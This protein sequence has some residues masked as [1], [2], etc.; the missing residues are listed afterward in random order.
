MFRYAASANRVAGR[1]VIVTCGSCAADNAAGRRFCDQCGASL[2]DAC[3]SC[4][5]QNRPEARF[6]GDC[7]Q[8]LGNGPDAAAQRAGSS[9]AVPIRSEPAAERRLVSVLFAD[10]VA[11][12]KYSEGRDPELVRETLTRYFESTRAVIERHGGQVEKFIGD[13]VMA[14]WGAQRAN[15]DDAER[16]V[17]AALEVVNAV[18]ELDEGLRARVGVLTGQAAVTLGATDQGMVAGDLVNTAARLQAVA[19]PDTVLVGEATMQAAT[20]AIAFEP[21]G[22]QVLKGKTAPV[23]AWRALRVVADKGGR[24]RGE[25]LEPPFVGREIELRLLKD[26]VNAASTEQRPRLVSITGPAG[27][28][29]S[30]LA[31]EFEKYVD[32]LVEQI[33][34]HRGRSPSYGEGIAFWALGEMVRRRAGLAEGDD[35]ATTRE[36]IHA[37]VSEFIAAGEAEWI[38]RS[39]LALLGLEAPPDGGRETLFAGWRTFFER[40]AARQTTVLVFED[41]QWADDGL[42]DFI[43]HLLEWSRDVP[44]LVVGLARPELLDERPGWG[45]GKRSFNAIGLEPLTDDQM[46]DLLR[47]LVP[48]MPD[49]AVAQVVARADGIPLYAVEMVR[50]LIADGSLVAGLDG[51]YAATRELGTLALPD[52]LRAL[53]ASRLDALDASDRALLQDA[54]I[55]GQ[56]FDH[57]ALARI[58][59]RDEDEVEARLRALMQ[60]ELVE[61]SVDPRSPD[62]GQYGFV[63]AVIREVA[64]ETLSRRDRRAR[65]LATARYYEAA[66][67]EEL[68]GV[69]AAHYLGAYKASDPGPEADA[70]GAQARRALV[71][72][73][74]R[75]LTLG[76]PAQALVHLES[77]LETT[78]DP[79]EQAGLLARAATAAS[80]AGRKD[81]AIDHAS[82]AAAI[83]DEAGQD[84]SALEALA[85][86]GGFQTDAGYDEDARKLL[87]EAAA[88]A[89]APEDADVRADLLAR[90]SRVHMR[91]QEEPEAIAA[92]DEALA[93]A[94]P[95]G[96]DRVTAEALINKSGTL[97][98]M[99]RIREPAILM[100]GA[101]DLAT[102]VGDIELQMRARA[103]LS[104]TYSHQ[105]LDLAIEASVEALEIARRL[106]TSG[107]VEWLVGGLVLFEFARGHDWDAAIELL[108]RAIDDTDADAD[109]MRYLFLGVRQQYLTMRGQETGGTVEAMR[110]ILASADFVPFQ[111]FDHMSAYETL[112]AGRPETAVREFQ[113]TYGVMARAIGDALAGC[114]IAAA[115]ARDVVAARDASKRLQEWDEGGRGGDAIRE[116]GRAVVHALEGR[117]ESATASFVR[118]VERM[119]AGKNHFWV[120]VLQAVALELQPGR[121]EHRSAGRRRPGRASSCWLPNPGCASSTLR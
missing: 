8:A 21:A 61:I 85:L 19:P 57:R 24:G 28:G 34:W 99:R 107:Y 50:M 13:A 16:A 36:R 71:S 115:Y 69:L 5:A 116:L 31:W 90:L 91:L 68:A 77:A 60:R 15:E 104:A 4:G 100:Q 114:S 105:D 37:A 6:C 25:G 74:A 81:L 11:F 82:R 76:S 12:T 65:H 92:A 118:A 102:E 66:G 9:A 119:R 109:Y 111:R 2:I 18:R 73:A 52:T 3:P 29:K 103:N 86:K 97:S 121:P 42:L 101:V 49:D 80:V 17:R 39:L 112:L 110:G 23:P 113:A 1:P 88:R 67:D 54:T 51:T 94:E 64:Y 47:G 40:I 63:Q 120:A 7:G 84:R 58:T 93:L 38:E 35:E 30:R 10:L 75:A 56:T 79:I 48:T 96:L 72:A 14:A 117:E 26:V 44:I 108:D 62:R 70:L 89:S 106:G 32:G 33:Y 45:T 53:V 83:F 59:D 27:I 20:G 46:R 41:L 95:L 98:Q 78:D 55:L 43:D 22:E 87:I